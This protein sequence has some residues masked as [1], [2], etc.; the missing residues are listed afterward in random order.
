MS[1]QGLR[2]AQKERMLERLIELDKARLDG[3]TWVVN[4]NGWHTKTYQALVDRGWAETRSDD[5]FVIHHRITE[6]GTQAIIDANEDRTRRGRPRKAAVETRPQ[7]PRVRPYEAEPEESANGR[8]PWRGDGRPAP[9]SLVEALPARKT[10][11]A[12][13]ESCIYKA[14]LTLAA[15]KYPGLTKLVEALEALR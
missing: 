4:N 5:S 10:N 11:C 3:Q 15:A 6:A 9:N 14:A 8:H 7:K 1:W 2:Q 12:Q 13:C